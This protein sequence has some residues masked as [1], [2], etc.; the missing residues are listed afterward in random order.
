VTVLWGA[1]ISGETYGRTSD[2]PWDATTW[3]TFEQHTGKK[4]SLIHWGQ[5]FGALDTNALNL[6]RQRGALS[7]ISVDFPVSAIVS[8]SQDGAI[9]AFA[10]KCAGWG[11]EILLRPGWEMNGGWYVWGRNPAY[12]KAWRRYVTRIRKI[13]P[14]V[15][16]VWCVNTIW[17]L[18]SDPAPYFP[19]P[20][21]V[22]WVGMDGYNRNEPWKSSGQVFD[23]TLSR[24]V[25]IAPTKRVMICEV[26]CTEK[27]GDK[28]AWIRHFLGAW[29][30][31]RPRVQA[32][33]QF[34]WNVFEDGVRRDWQIESSSSAQSAF[35][36]GIT[37]SYY[38][39][40]GA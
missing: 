19:G 32:F 11:G 22:D 26:G 15:K 25:E 9:D 20:A 36:K 35:R 23:P 2:A 38:R 39:P 37:S 24:L 6:A 5:P 4:V 40:P 28:A 1:R 21:Y 27:G 29:L 16:F 33:A 13:A 31:G 14:N 12:A 34:N 3:S 10:Q 17:D 8:G 7:L 18:A 30:P